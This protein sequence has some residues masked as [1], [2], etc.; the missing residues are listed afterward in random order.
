M[1][2]FRDR[3]VVLGSYKFGEADRVVVLLT[4][5]H[6]KVRAVARGVRKTK[7]SIGARLEPLNHVDVSFRRG[8]QLDTVA[9][10]TL[11]EPF[12]RL[13]GDFERMAQGIAMLEAVNKM[14][15]DREPV[16]HI[17]EILVRALRSLD[18]RVAPLTLA[19]FFWRIL[20]VE[21]HEPRLDECV[22]CGEPVGDGNDGG[23]HFDATHGGVHCAA[24]RTG[25]PISG[26]ALAI[27]RRM[28][29]GHMNEAL[30]LGESPPV[31]EVN[32]LAMDAME[33]HLERRLQSLG[34]FDRHL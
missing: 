29:G 8:R 11:A 21:G 18:A 16:P 1:K 3:A 33:A 17:Y 12:T 14:T 20:Q 31:H 19:G 7:S 27:L 10:V 30:A 25:I 24:C 34:V 28:L 9:E 32:R 13:R 4:E 26:A 22:G 15:P 23:L 6:G 5:T 2:S